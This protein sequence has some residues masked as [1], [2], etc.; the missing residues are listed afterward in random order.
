LHDD[1]LVEV[2]LAKDRMERCDHWHCEVP[3]QL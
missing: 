1:S 3:Q 2:G